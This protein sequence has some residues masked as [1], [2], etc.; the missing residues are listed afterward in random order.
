MAEV[1]PIQLPERF[2]RIEA[3][4]L[5]P[6]L[7]PAWSGGEGVRWTGEGAHY[8]ALPLANG[9]GGQKAKIKPRYLNTSRKHL[10]RPTATFSPTDA[11]K[12]SFPDRG[13]EEKAD[14][15]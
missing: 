14:G 15:R 13:G 1:I 3:H 6:F 9:I 5:T 2:C 12:G 11:E 10:I 7:S 8:A 4:S